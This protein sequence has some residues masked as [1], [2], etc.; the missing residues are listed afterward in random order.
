MEDPYTNREIIEKFDYIKQSLC[1]I[2]KQ[3]AKITLRVD[4]LE[5]RSNYARGVVKMAT[6]SALVVIV[7]ILGWLLW[8]VSHLDDTILRVVTQAIAAHII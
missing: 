1:R 4:D 8:T 2:E 6:I 3:T 5:D 7:P